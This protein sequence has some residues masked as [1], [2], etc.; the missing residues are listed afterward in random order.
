MLRRLHPLIASLLLPLFVVQATGCTQVVKQP[1]SEPAPAST[2]ELIGVTTLAGQ[3][4]EFD[5]IGI[6][7][8][9]TVRA[10]SEKNVVSIPVDSVQRWWIRK[11]DP[12]ATAGLVILGAAVVVGVIAVASYDGGGGSCTSGCESCPFVYSWN[13]SDFVFDAEPFGGALT[14]GLQRDDY[15]V[16]RNLASQDGSY[17]LLMVNQMDETQMTNL[18][19]LWSVTHAPGTRIL[20]DEWGGLHTITAAIAPAHATVQGG[21]DLTKWVAAD[22]GLIWEPRPVAD[23]GGGLLDELVLTFPRP[24][25]ATQAKFITRVGTSTWG[26]HMVRAMLELRGRQVQDWYHLV[27]SSTAAA[28]SVRTWAISEAL[29]GT[30]V[31]VETADG[32][33]AAGVMG[34]GGPYMAQARVIVLDLPPATGDSLRIR[35]RTARGFWAFNYFAMDYSADQPV[36]V[37]TLRLRAGSASNGSD[38]LS[39]LSSADS[40]FYEMPLSGDRAELEFADVPQRPG[41]ERTVLLH[42]RGWYHLHLQSKSE[43]DTALLRRIETV[44]GA[45]AEYSAEL[46]RQQPMAA[47]GMP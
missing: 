18:T 46:Y 5:G 47:L 15:N 26:S 17:R 7:K 27:D 4:V 28:D 25:G 14:L 11:S 13:G 35:I 16:L 37:D 1:A 42:T 34:G 10:T 22:D 44:P 8:D 12:A 32:W 21:V 38:L 19:E 20:P 36:A 41:T 23:E 43:A 30:E 3:H 40:R 29:Y 9:D 24:A 2:E 31:E 33:E 45:T 6:V 39:L